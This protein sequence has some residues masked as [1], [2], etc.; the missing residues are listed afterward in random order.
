M[1]ALNSVAGEHPFRGGQLATP[2]RPWHRKV[3]LGHYEHASY[4]RP[5]YPSLC[6]TRG[7]FSIL[8]S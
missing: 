2:R 1:L 3:R 7:G 8:E 5:W 6:G 4:T